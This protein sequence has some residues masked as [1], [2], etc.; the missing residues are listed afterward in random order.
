[1]NVSNYIKTLASM[2]GI[3]ADDEQLKTLLAN[4]NLQNVEINDDLATKINGSILTVDSAKN[5]S[6]LNKHFRAT[7]L[8][9]LDAE[10]TSLMTQLEL[11]DETRS[12]IMGEQSSFKRVPLLVNKIKALE[13]AKSNANQGDKSKLQEEIDRLNQQILDTTKGFETKLAENNTQWESRMLDMNMATMLSNYDYA[14]PASKD[15]NILTAKTLLNKEINEKG[16][17]VV[18]DEFGNMKLVKPTDDGVMDY[19]E[20]NVKVGIQDFTDGILTANKLLK[21]NNGDANNGQPNPTVPQGGATPPI[22]R[23]NKMMGTI[24]QMIADAENK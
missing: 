5:N 1:M 13:S 2:A 11:D 14:F 7:I 20:N 23:G 24:E 18:N 22:S 9:G 15:V 8:N 6:D 21:T 17:Q 16:L 10:M 12:E 4:E 3:S 19:Y